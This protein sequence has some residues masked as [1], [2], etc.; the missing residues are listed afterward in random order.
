MR[1]KIQ[2]FTS[3]LPCSSFKK[4]VVLTLRLLH[5]FHM[6]S[7]AKAV[8]DGLKDRKCK[9]IALCKHPPIPCPQKGLC[10]RDGFVFQGQSSQDADQQR[11]RTLSSYLALRDVQSISHSRMIC[12]RYDQEIGIF[13]D[14]RRSK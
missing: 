1:A 14:P 13:Q 8:P 7:L 5:N 12:T 3:D 9:T 6:M 4:L 2:L 10:S 11:Y